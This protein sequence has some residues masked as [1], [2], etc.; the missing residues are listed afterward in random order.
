VAKA[1]VTD[2]TGRQREEQIKAHAEELAQK[3][4]QISMATQTQ[5][6]KDETEVLDL[7]APNK[8]ATVI[9]EVESV[10]VTLADDTQVIR[11]AEDLEFVTIG[12]G[13]HFSFKAGKKYKVAKHV[14][15]HLQ[16]KGYLYD[17]L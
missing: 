16:E 2:V 9:D 12:A 15:A 10:G 4:S 14:A 17:R 7:T 1:K 3:A 5:V 11:V 6:Y 8:P 13:N